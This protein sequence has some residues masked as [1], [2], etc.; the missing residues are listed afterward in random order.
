MTM[1]STKLSE[2]MKSTQ[3]QLR[4]LEGVLGES[5]LNIERSKLLTVEGSYKHKLKIPACWKFSELKNVIEIVGGSQPPKSEFHSESGDGL[6]RL[7]QIRDYKSNKHI[8]YIP[9]EKAR[10]F[11]NKTEIMIG[12]Y[13]PP[14]FQILRGLEGAYNV[15]LM[16]AIPVQECMTNEYLFYYLS[17]RDIY[18]YVE[19]A[20]DRTAGQSGVNKAHLEKYPVGLPPLAEQTVIVQALDTLLAQVDNIKSRLEAIPK[21]LKTF[22]QSV[23]AAAVSGKLTEAFRGESECECELSAWVSSSI[24]DVATVATGT[25][26][27]RTN[28]DYWTGGNIPWLTSASTGKAFT[29]EAEQFVTALAVKE[30][31]LKL[32]GPGTLLIA[33][34][35]E[36]KTRGQVTE[37]K[38][39]AT[40]NQACAAII[41]NEEA[42]SKEFIKL[43]LIENYE[44]TR[45]VAAGGAQPNLNLGKVRDIS[46]CLPPLKEQAQIVYRVEELFAFADQI[47]E[48]VRNAQGRVN[49]LTQSILAKA[50]RGELTAKWRAENSDLISG[51]NSAQALLAAIQ[52]ECK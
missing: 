6:I 13:G 41:V 11:V 46:I 19:S 25:T 7:I 32:F 1:D 33:M 9:R 17:G 40:C 36:G 42:V 52:L 2:Q 15:A 24:G 51:K 23:L 8:V 39:T 28:L 29:S 22:R 35:G 4:K 26:P 20:S 45:K 43:I 38:M 16:K 49:N 3:E 14:I 44:E 34:Y 18:N 50:F 48:Q 27:K 31:R 47:E 5:E 12:R 37:L 10:R 21:I 30:S